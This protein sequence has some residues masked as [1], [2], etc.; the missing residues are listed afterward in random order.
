MPAFG[1]LEF[2]GET[3][4]LTF[5]ETT[6]GLGA[7]VDSQQIAIDPADSVSG[8]DAVVTICRDAEG[9]SCDTRVYRTLG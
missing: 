3:H 7:V 4:Q 1:T 5:R 6:N 8:G 2:A 9:T